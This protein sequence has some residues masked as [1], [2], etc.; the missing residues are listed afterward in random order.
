MSEQ[1]SQ[2][3]A[4]VQAGDVSELDTSLVESLFL[5]E[6]L[7]LQNPDHI[8]DLEGLLSPSIS[9]VPAP[10]PAPMAIHGDIN[11]GGPGSAANPGP[12]QDVFSGEMSNLSAAHPSMKTTA[13]LSVRRFLKPHILRINQQAQSSRMRTGSAVASEVA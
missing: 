1:A 6:M 5:N 9:P 8:F 7:A 12:S 2:Q 4:P 3:P 13:T 11:A 10:A